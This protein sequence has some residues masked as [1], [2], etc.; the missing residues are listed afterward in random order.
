MKHDFSGKYTNYKVPDRKHQVPAGFEST[1]ESVRLSDAP[2]LTGTN[3]YLNVKRFLF[4]VVF[5]V[6]LILLFIT[7]LMNY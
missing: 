3:I 5:K 4:V 6:F 2:C 1:D 7:G